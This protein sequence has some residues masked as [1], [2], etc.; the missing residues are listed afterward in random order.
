M[1]LRISLISL[2]LLGLLL[3]LSIWPG[4]SL[5]NW[6]WGLLAATILTVALAGFFWQFERRQNSIVQLSFIATISS[7][8]ALSRIAFVPIAGLQPASFIIMITGYV[9]GSQTG[10]LVGAISALVSNFFLGQGPWTPWQM[11]AWGI[12]GLLAGCLGQAL[13]AFR[14]LPFVFLCTFSAFLFGWITNIS[15]WSSF[16]HP[17]N[18]SSYLGSCI[19]SFPFDLIH[20][21]GNLAFS[22]LF[23]THFYQLLFRFQAKMSGYSK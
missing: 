3:L 14:L 15:Y 21:A 2:G 18:W 22:L 7:L 11:L 8:A 9:F 17:L 19:T 5:G 6:N 16:V 13:S 23:G 4:R 20:A 12:C 10:F 1:Q